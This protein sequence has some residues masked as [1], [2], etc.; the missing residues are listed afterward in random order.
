MNK[1]ILVIEDE[2]NIAETLADILEL[3]GFEVR[4]A[5]DGET[6]FSM[7]VE[8]QPDLILCDVMMPKMDGYEVLEAVRNHQQMTQV[9][10]I[11][12]TA[13]DHSQD[14]RTGMNLGADDY[15]TKPVE[16]ET[17]VRTIENRLKKHNELLEIGH[18]EENRRM[19]KD[20]HDTLQQTLLGLQMKLTRFREKHV[21][22]M[23]VTAIDE[24]LDYIKLAFSQFR[25]I[26]EHGTAFL[27]EDGFVAGLEK[28]INRISQ[29]VDFEIS[30]QNELES[31][32]PKAK[33]SILF[34]AF[35]EILNNAIKH[36]RANK[37]F[38]HLTKEG[39]VFSIVI[40]DDGC[41]FD[42]DSIPSGSGLANIKDRIKELQGK[43]SI[44][45]AEGNGTAIEILLE[46]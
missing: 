9:P 6:G 11:F 2:I 18:T 40:L 26:L 3:K 14:F 17:L 39:P 19:N 4:T 13:K 34:K 33:A 15:L 10:F 31:E 16:I 35:L 44:D 20:L 5:P 25:M 32:I 38:I 42:P 30:I 37:L 24:S 1:K 43:I 45:S 12:L 41:G 21:E 46:E 28:L 29:Y 7:A 8:E 23:D 22:F 27:Q 36:S